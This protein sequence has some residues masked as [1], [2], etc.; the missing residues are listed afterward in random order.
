[1]IMRCCEASGLGKNMP[2]AETDAFRAKF[3]S[4]KHARYVGVSPIP[5]SRCLRPPTAEGAKTPPMGSGS[6]AGLP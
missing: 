3:A 5:S 1:M 4:R 2:G 6:S